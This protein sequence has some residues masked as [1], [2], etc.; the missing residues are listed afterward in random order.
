MAG[1]GEIFGQLFS[2]LK[3]L[4][5]VQKIGAGVAFAVVLGTMLVLVM[6]GEKTENYQIL[7]S[8][9]TQEDAAAIVDKL[10][11]SRQPYK[12]ENNGT[13]ILVPK[14]KVL[15][16]RLTIAGDGLP[17][18]GGVGFEIFD[19]TS[20]GTTDFVQKLNYQRALQGELARTIKQFQQVQS[21]RIHIATPKE[22]V[23]VDEEKQP[24]ASVSLKMSGRE[25]LNK[26]EV[27]AIVN[28]VA[29][30][31]PGLTS[32]NITIVDTAGNLLFR[33]EKDEIG[34][35]AATQLEYQYK[36]ESMLRRKVESILSEVVGEEHVQATV[37]AELEF[38]QVDV[39]EEIFDPEGKVE[40]STQEL[41]EEDSENALDPEGIPGVKGQLATYSE[42][43]EGKGKS[44]K[45]ENRTKNYEI[46][47]KTKQTRE[48]PGVIKRLAVAVM[49]DGTYKV[50]DNDGAEEIEY[51]SRDDKELADFENMV[52][53]AINFDPERGDQVK[54]LNMQFSDGFV[55][56]K[57]QDPVEK[58][59][60][61]LEKLI[62]PIVYLLIAVAGFFLVVR[63]LVRMIA[64]KQLEAQREAAL[65]EAEAARRKLVEEEEEELN[66]SPKAMS[67]KEKI[68]K[69][70]QSDP[71]RAAD[72]V[73][74]WLREEG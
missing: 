23:F 66:L 40:R 42:K 25:K 60:K 68:Y 2:T 15:D 73:R 41:I 67:D 9:L 36:V 35:L 37:T 38:N 61:Y 1:P 32:E 49:I 29:S 27:Q 14:D 4:S 24:S 28:L 57:K 20:L 65:H 6:G 56:E 39:T 43:E 51:V 64:A 47:R 16:V 21:A 31:V 70:A 45:R 46:S 13:A 72:L 26:R 11:E 48:A 22:S 62:I 12:L 44:H 18:G 7:F 71:D 69:L 55:P 63:P 10:R 53:T 59:E 19:K 3:E 52:K 54:V 34:L 33:K 17:R 8:N 58:W 74:R 30:A 5:T 50:I